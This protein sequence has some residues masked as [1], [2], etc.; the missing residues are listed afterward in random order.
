MEVNIPITWNSILYSYLTIH[1]IGA[2]IAH[3]K[4][5]ADIKPNIATYMKKADERYPLTSKAMPLKEDEI[6]RV[7]RH[8]KW[9]LLGRL[10]AWLP[11]KIGLVI[12]LIVLAPILCLYDLIACSKPFDSA[13]NIYGLLFQWY[14]RENYGSVQEMYQEWF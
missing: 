6:S 2:I 8:L 14:N 12:S 4:N 3:R 5:V 10:I 9:L 1:I 11:I 13:R 7:N